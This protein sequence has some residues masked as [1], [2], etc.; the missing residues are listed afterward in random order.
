VAAVGDVEREADVGGGAGLQ[1]VDG[2]GIGDEAVGAARAVEIE[3]AVGRRLGDVEADMRAVGDLA[4]DRVSRGVDGVAVG[5]GQRAGDV[6]ER[7]V[8]GGVG[9]RGAGHRGR[10]ARRVVGAD[11]IDGQDLA[12]GQVAAVGDVEREADVGGGA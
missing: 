5:G 10:Q 9:Q 2:A 3:R 1:R 8:G 6:G 11:Q 12:V 4:G 7:V